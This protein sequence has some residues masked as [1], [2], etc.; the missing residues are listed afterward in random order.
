MAGKQLN[1]RVITKHDKEEN[2][3][4]A[5]SFIPKLGELIVYET[6]GMYST[7]RLKVGNGL[8]VIK[9]LP[10]ITDAYVEKESGK[11]LSSNDFTD[12][13]RQKLINIPNDAKFTDTTYTAGAGLGLDG[14][15]FY[16]KSLVSVGPGQSNGTIKVSYRI[17]PN[18]TPEN[19]D[20]GEFRI[21]GLTDTAFTTLDTLY[22]KIKNG[23]QDGTIN[24]NGNDISITGLNEAAFMSIQELSGKI[25]GEAAQEVYIG[26]NIEENGSAKIWIKEE[27]D[28]GLMHLY[29]YD[30]EESG[31]TEFETSNIK[32]IEEV[33]DE[34]S[35]I[36][37]V[38]AFNQNES[39]LIHISP[40]IQFFSTETGIIDIII[41]GQEN[42]KLPI[43]GLI[44]DPVYPE[45]L[46]FLP[47]TGGTITGPT[48]F[49]NTTAATSTTTGAVTISGGLGVAGD[50][51]CNSVN[52]S[53]ANDYAEYRSSTMEIQPGKVVY[54]D[55]NGLL[56]TTVQRLQ[57]FEGV[58]S[59]T[60]GFSIGKDDKN[61]TP[62]AVSGRVLVYTDSDKEN[63]HNGDVVCAAPNGVVSR[64]T[65]E[66][67]VKYPDR[68]VGIVSEIPEYEYWGFNNIKVNNR[69]WI[70]VK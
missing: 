52:G 38:V 2:W 17:G 6:D 68:I 18:E 51:Y 9:K 19:F 5:T 59:D 61:Q 67:I 44:D 20:N 55:D 1:A 49:T 63:F 13:L 54:C 66:E 62:L 30:D 36:F 64:M 7:P 26:Q 33:T 16:N 53:I 3:N 32:K 56:K 37:K 28:T 43:A 15:K 58:V 65:R 39:Y 11:G 27:L 31:F 10:F 35:G 12:F 69:I 48:S 25:L 42:V 14:T 46:A 40:D 41:G 23:T 29:Y 60:F 21:T 4:K 8:D 57:R 45:L 50:I 22:S 24:V 47:L 34:G 70:R